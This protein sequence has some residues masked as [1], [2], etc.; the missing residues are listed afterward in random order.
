MPK[1]IIFISLLFLSISSFGQKIIST[2]LYD[3]GVEYFN[4]N[5]FKTADSLFTASV[6]S[7]PNV[8]AYYNLALS[9]LKS[10]D[11]CNFCHSLKKASLLGDTQ[12]TGYY[13]KFCSNNMEA[14]MDFY[15]KSDLVFSKIV[16]TNPNPNSYFDLALTRAKLGDK[17][18]FCRFLDSASFYRNK[19]D[20]LWSLFKKKCCL[21]KTMQI[22]DSAQKDFKIFNIISTSSCTGERKE[23]R[24]IKINQ[25]N[26]TVLDYPVSAFP[27]GYIVRIDNTE[28]IGV[29]KLSLYIDTISSDLDQLN[30]NSDKVKYI[31]S[32]EM[33]SF[34]GGEMDMYSWLGNNIK[35]PIDAKETGVAGIVIITFVIEKDGS[36]TD[37]Q[38]LNG[39]GAGCDEEAVRVIK[40]M[41]KWIP[42]KQNGIPVRTQFNLPIR[43]TLE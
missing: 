18:A 25:Q 15:K 17:C 9:K 7:Y 35:Y 27:K 43:F 11:T 14:M 3:K 37:V 26:D 36:L 31:I 10:G 40:A 34:P 22:I 2:E 23:F 5:D 30:C 13:D 42:G 39:I 32:E 29:Q 6:E 12:S 4:K 16:N 19:E 41:P 28:L 24:F 20:K 33:A 38:V 1:K 8:D 21:N